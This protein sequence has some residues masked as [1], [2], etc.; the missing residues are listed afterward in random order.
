MYEPREENGPA[1]I[2]Q[3]DI[4]MLLLILGDAGRRWTKKREILQSAYA[5]NLA[6]KRWLDRFVPA[7]AAACNGRV[8]STIEGY[9][10][11]EHSSRALIERSQSQI[12]LKAKSTAKRATDIHSYLHGILRDGVI[13]PTS[14][15]EPPPPP[16][17]GQQELNF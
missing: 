16:K 9:R 7:I 6:G 12:A 8:I 17:E 14:D 13:L 5:F 15:E 2:P 4:D 3:H 1:P 11:Q 10:L